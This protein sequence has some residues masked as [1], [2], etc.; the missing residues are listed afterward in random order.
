MFTLTIASQF[1]FVVMSKDFSC[2]MVHRCC[3][4]VKVIMSTVCAMEW[5]DKSFT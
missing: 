2:D 3:A 5:M 4:E 1:H